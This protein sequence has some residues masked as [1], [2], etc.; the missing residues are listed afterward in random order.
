VV[1]SSR[2]VGALGALGHEENVAVMVMTRST[3]GTDTGVAGARPRRT[4]ARAPR[5]PGGRAIL[6]G[7]LVA[8]AALG[9][10][11]AARSSGTPD[12]SYAVAARAIPPG[13]T[14]TS[15]HVRFEPIDLPSGVA[16]SAFAEAAQ[17]DGRVALGPIREGELVQVGQVSDRGPA[18]P[19]A[20]L[21][22]S[23]ERDRAVD[24]R[25]RSGDLVDVFVTYDDRTAAVAE[26]MRLVD[27]RERDDGSLARGTGLTVTLA[28]TDPDDRAALI[29]AARAGDVTL[30]RSTHMAGA[31]ASTTSGAD[32]AGAPPAGPVGPQDDPTAPAAAA[33]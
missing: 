7:L 3:N 16:A 9:T 32:G 25:L 23:L 6:G 31:G 20:E 4:I 2:I 26:A 22:F 11:V 10:F 24:G 14:L 33:G 12:R 5:L 30:V 17:L 15:D 28:I 13:E 18:D 8:A 1:T 29:H 19:A 21:S 27:V